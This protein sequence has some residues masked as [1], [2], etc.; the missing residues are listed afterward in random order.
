MENDLYYDQVDRSNEANIDM[1]KTT[2]K[3]IVMISHASMKLH[4]V[5]ED[6]D[7][8]RE[9][10]KMLRKKLLHQREKLLSSKDKTRILEAD[11]IDMENKVELLA[12]TKL[13]NDFKETSDLLSLELEN[14]EKLRKSLGHWW[15]GIQKIQ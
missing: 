5:K 8:M 11:R 7:R 12:N 13:L 14:N 3:N 9:E 1:R 15:E 2:A 4:F 6:A 10:E